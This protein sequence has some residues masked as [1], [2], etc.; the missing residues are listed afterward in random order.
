MVL[1]GLWMMHGVSAMSGSGCH[2]GPMPLLAAT[3]D[4]DAMAAP[5][6]ARADG[7]ASA[8]H[9]GAMSNGQS[10]E[11]CVPDQPQ[12]SGAAL[13]ALLA[14]MALVGCV[15]RTA[16]AWAIARSA[17]RRR[18]PPRPSGSDLLT[19]VCVSRT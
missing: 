13:I 1:A 6:Q 18:A 12:T 14:L 19:V 9:S 15:S 2:G 5:A 11:V 8:A 4:G 7:S 17:R 3:S 16:W 10:G